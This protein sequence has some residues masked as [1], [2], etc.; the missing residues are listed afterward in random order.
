MFKRYFLG[1]IHNSI[2]LRITV[3]WNQTIRLFIY[4]FFNHFLYTH[5]SSF[6]PCD[7]F[8]SNS[9]FLILIGPRPDLALQ[10]TVYAKN[11]VRGT[12]WTAISWNS[13]QGAT[14]RP[15]GL[16]PYTYVSPEAF[17][18]GSLQAGALRAGLG[19]PARFFLPGNFALYVGVL[20]PDRSRDFSQTL[21][22]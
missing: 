3:N 9:N 14:S 18:Q 15:V 5:W 7:L 8:M 1:L 22:I 11:P 13:F 6:C 16:L 20:R 2:T 21:N 17:L 12:S 4:I 10:I 19:P